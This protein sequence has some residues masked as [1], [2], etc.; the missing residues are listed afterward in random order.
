VNKDNDAKIAE[1]LRLQQEAT[2]RMMYGV[3]HGIRSDNTDAL[4]ALRGMNRKQRRTALAQAR[5]VGRK[6]SK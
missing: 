5:I 4:R 6:M 1:E 2:D 3:K